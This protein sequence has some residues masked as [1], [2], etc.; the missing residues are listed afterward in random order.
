[1]GGLSIISIGAGFFLLTP[2]S[3]CRQCWSPFILPE[4]RDPEAKPGLDW[5]GA[6]LVLIGLGS[7]TY[8]LIALP[9]LKWSDPTVLA[10]ISAGLI[11]LGAFVWVEGHSRAPM[12]P[13]T[14]FR[15]RAFSLINILTL[16]LYGALGGVFFFLPFALI[17]V[18]GYPAT[19]AGATFLLSR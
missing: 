18:R 5:Q 11:L 6:L 16:L 10:S 7:I 17:Q 13:L 3:Q 12:L 9:I 1:V 15:S 2:S 19:F 8:G 4:S 14:I